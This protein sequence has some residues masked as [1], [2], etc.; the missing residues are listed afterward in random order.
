MEKPNVKYKNEIINNQSIKVGI[1]DLVMV[2]KGIYY[3]FANEG[4]EPLKITE[5]KIPLEVAF[6]QDLF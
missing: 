2:P 5:H 4:S 3:A 1:G 6:N